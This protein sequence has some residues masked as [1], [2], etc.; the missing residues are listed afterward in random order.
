[1][2][3]WL[4]VSAWLGLSGTVVALRLKA[5][6]DLPRARPLSPHKPRPVRQLGGERRLASA[7]AGTGRAGSRRAPRSVSGAQR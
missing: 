1:M 6:R 3:V 5:T 4:F 7:R 2:T